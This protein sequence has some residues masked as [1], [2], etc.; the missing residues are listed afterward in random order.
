MSGHSPSRLHTHHCEPRAHAC[1][2]GRPC[3]LLLGTG[4]AGCGRRWVPRGSRAR[5][6]QVS[7]VVLLCAA[8]LARLWHQLPAPHP[9]T[10]IPVALSPEPWMAVGEDEARAATEPTCCSLWSPVEPSS[11][12]VWRRESLPFPVLRLLR[13]PH[14]LVPHLSG[15]RSWGIS[16]PRFTPVPQPPPQ[17]T[18]VPPCTISAPPESQPH[19]LVRPKPPPPSRPASGMGV[20]GCRRGRCAVLLCRPHAWERGGPRELCDHADLSRGGNNGS[21][22]SNTCGS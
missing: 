20:G 16:F 9:P 3:S 11:L 12:G 5:S 21:T 8:F 2:P 4:A 19:H 15:G 1:T 17:P 6:A 10:M 18:P 22:D 7:G 14:C 13:R